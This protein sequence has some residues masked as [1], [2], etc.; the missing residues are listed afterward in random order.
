MKSGRSFAQQVP[1]KNK[2]PSV[3]FQ[4]NP[5]VSDQL[6]SKKIPTAALEV[7]RKQNELLIQQGRK[8]SV[9]SYARPSSSSSVCGTCHDMGVENGWD[10]WQAEAGENYDSLGLNLTSTAP[11][12]PRFNMTSGAGIDP[13]TP[14]VNPGDPPITLVAPPGFGTSSIQLGQPQT[15]GQGGGCVTQQSPLAAGCA[16]RLTYCFTVGVADTNFIYAY[17]F[18]MENPNDS[19]HT[20][21][22]MPYVEFMILDANG[23]TIPCAYQRYIA[24]ESFPGQYTCNAVRGGGGGGGGGGGRDSAIYKPWTIEGVNLS[25]F[26]GQTLTVVITNADCR[27]GG[28]FA[29]SYWDFACGSTSAILKPNCYTNAPDTLI[30]P[31]PPDSVNTYSY[32]WFLNSNPTPIATTQMITP[33]AQ[34]GDT[35]LVKIILPSGCNWYARYVPQHFSVTADYIFSTRCGFADFTARSFSPSVEDPINYWSWNFSGGIPATSNASNPA[36]VTFTPGNHTVTLISGT[37]SPGCRDTIQ[38]TVNVPQIPVAAF[39]TTNVCAYQQVPINNTSTVAS[40]DTISSYSWNIVG[41]NPATSSV[42]NP[43]TTIANPGTSQITLTVNTTRGCTNTVQQNVTIREVPVASFTSTSV[44]FGQQLTT[45]NTSTISASG[46]TLTYVWSFPG[47][48]PSTSSSVSPVVS[49]ATADTFPVVLIAN[50][51]N[52]C[53][54]TITQ[55]AIVH[56]QPIAGFTT[57]RVCAGAAGQF[58]NTSHVVSGDTTLSF[59]WTLPGG[60]PT[61]STAANPSI[62][63]NALDTTDVLLIAMNNYGCRDTIQLPVI[64]SANPT[65]TFNA[66]SFCFGT[67]LQIQNTS[68][69]QPAGDSLMFSWSITGG[70]PASSSV[71]NPLVN[72]ALSGT[73]TI[74]LIASAIGGCRDT[75]QR[76]IKIHPLPNADVLVPLS[77]YGTPVTINNLSSPFAGDTI[78]SYAWNIGNAIPA[79]SSLTQPVVTF[80]SVDTSLVQLITTTIHGCR[81]TISKKVIVSAAP[82]AD[83]SLPNI[84]AESEII[85]ANSSFTQ[86]I[87]ENITYAWTIAGGSLTSSSDASPLVSFSTEGAFRVSLIVRADGGCADTTEHMLTVFPLPQSLFSSPTGCKNSTVTLVNQSTVFEDLIRNYYWSFP[88]GQPSTSQ[89]INP[90]IRFDTAGTFTT[91]LIAVTQHGCRDTSSGTI[92]VYELPVIQ[93]NDPDS[94]CAPLCHTFSDQSVSTDGTISLWSWSFPGGNPGNSD[95]QNPDEICYTT[96]GFYNADLSVMSEF[97]CTAQKSFH[98][99]IKVY[100]NPVADFNTSAETVNYTA[101]LITFKDQ[102]S[103]NVV[104]WLWNFGD[105]SATVNGGPFETYSY[106]STVFNDFYH[107]VASLIVTTEHGCKDTTFKPVEITPEY[108]F[109]VPNAFTPNGDIKNNLF[110]AKGLGIKNYDI[111]ILDRWGLEIWSCHQDGSNILWDVYGNEGMSSSCQ[112]DGTNKGRQVQQDVY[113]WKAHVT[114]IFGKQHSYIGTVTVYF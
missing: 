43:V 31:A 19:S 73:S 114:D 75:V 36:S 44:C 21:V 49:F 20:L 83:F 55:N 111:W 62:T 96:P 102:S 64:I 35:F 39:T 59:S 90:S 78:A 88:E 16:E 6:K 108:T 61:Y 37:Y 97:G 24:S 76:I 81:D 58:R 3:F 60:T 45:Q 71:T 74:T 91:S 86:P 46:G 80:Q 89:L 1:D 85:F 84:C 98:N 110:Y 92:R 100:P 47:G 65:A 66:S 34:P 105:S 107:F 17:A 93:I 48:T 56:S 51:M 15:D 63:F 40:S 2:N 69:I 82:H 41:G 14:G 113:V 28:H 8:L 94:G 9:R 27:L 87:G 13:L 109:F 103:A 54:D 101:P 67:P 5:S 77:C 95:S 79:V 104:Q 23:D 12:P 112:W 72:Y 52:G 22:T 53:A 70:Q 10:V 30:A 7:I 11:A 29:H 57:P 68:T 18:V 26:I 38:Y 32:Q 25:S 4:E 106:S 33:Y 42:R 50:S 99:Y